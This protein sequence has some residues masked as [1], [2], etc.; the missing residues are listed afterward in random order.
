MS[1]TFSADEVFEMAEQIERNGAKFYRLAAQSP[2]NSALKRF[3]EELADM[4]I[5]HI[6]IF[7]K[8]RT[9]LTGSDQLDMFDP[10]DDAAKYLHAVVKGRI[11]DVRSEPSE[12]LTA[13]KTPQDVLNVAIELEK[14]SI[15]FYLAMKSRVPSE[16]GKT[17]ID[18]I[19]MQEMGH[20]LELKDKLDSID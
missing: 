10:D 17:K 19:I 11:F 1:I 5:E 2:N 16:S 4:E 12:K 6:K 15:V 9:E 18:A 13:C 3:L 7:A 20:V 14:D 8:I